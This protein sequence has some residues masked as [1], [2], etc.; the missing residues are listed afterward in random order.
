MAFPPRYNS[1]LISI[2]KSDQ[3]VGVISSVLT[4]GEEN[5]DYKAWYFCVQASYRF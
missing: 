1:E 2:Y 5:P 3:G 4:M